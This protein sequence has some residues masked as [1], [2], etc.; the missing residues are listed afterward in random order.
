MFILRRIRREYSQLSSYFHKI[1][2]SHL[3]MTRPPE[4]TRDFIH[5]SLYNQNYG[6]FMK[7]VNIIHSKESLSAQES[8]A[9]DSILLTNNSMRSWETPL[10]K[11]A[12]YTDEEMYQNQVA[13]LYQTHG[14]NQDNMYH[15]LW[16]TPST[17]LKVSYLVSLGVKNSLY[18]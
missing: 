5:D 6:Y 13:I 3:K 18:K 12:D 14:F 9:N 8:P 1:K 16:H 10:L 17:L 15:Q 4:L 2:A 11:I 7:H